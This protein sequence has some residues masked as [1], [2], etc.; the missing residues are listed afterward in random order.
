VAEMTA[1]AKTRIDAYSSAS[2]PAFQTNRQT[3]PQGSFRTEA[4]LA[5]PERERRQAVLF[6]A[7]AG[8]SGAVR[9]SLPFFDSSLSAFTS[10]PSRFRENYLA[11]FGPGCRTAA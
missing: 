5:A 6:C 3:E 1:A 4:V 7:L 2:R 9:L 11:L 10:P 8:V